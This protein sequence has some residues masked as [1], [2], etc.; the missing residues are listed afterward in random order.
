ML[1]RKDVPP[2][3]PKLGR[4]ST[5]LELT[6]KRKKPRQ[7]GETLAGLFA[8]AGA[9]VTAPLEPPPHGRSCSPDK[10]PWRKPWTRWSASARRGCPP[11]ST[12]QT[13][14]RTSTRRRADFY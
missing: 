12:I 10:A 13:S 3:P 5:P 7:G 8:V 11:L 1:A 14:G 9:I 6:T 2:L 4:L